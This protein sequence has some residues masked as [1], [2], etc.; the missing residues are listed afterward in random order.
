MR[1]AAI[2]IEG[3]V[4]G[5]CTA[6]LERQLKDRNRPGV[7]LTRSIWESGL[8]RPRKSVSNPNLLAV[9]RE[10]LKETKYLCSVC[11]FQQMLRYFF[12]GEFHELEF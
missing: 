9:F 12:R 7:T 10:P 11:L 5:S 3:L 1:I 8:L 2:R 4:W 6:A